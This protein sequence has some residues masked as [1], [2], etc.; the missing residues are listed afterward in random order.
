MGDYFIYLGQS[1]MNEL[2]V[3]KVLCVLSS[4]L[5]WCIGDYNDKK[6]ELP[7]YRGFTLHSLQLP[8][9]FST[10]VGENLNIVANVV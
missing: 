1:D 8:P 9:R 2:D 6:G 10:G 4:I 5:L 3:I 7:L